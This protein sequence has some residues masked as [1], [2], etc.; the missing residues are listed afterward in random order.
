VGTLPSL[1]NAGAGSLTPV[2]TLY[3]SKGDALSADSTPS[4]ASAL[5]PGAALALMAR[6]GSLLA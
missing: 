5:V 6:L 1:F 3:N 4:A 2:G